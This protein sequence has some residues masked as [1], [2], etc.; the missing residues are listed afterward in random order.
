MT[1]VAFG[2]FDWID[3]STGASAPALQGPV[4]APRGGG[5]SRLL[6]LSPCGASRDPSRYGAIPSSSSSPPPLPLPLSARPPPPPL[7]SLPALSL[8]PSFSPSPPPSLPPPLLL[9]PSLLSLLFLLPSLPSPSSSP[10]H[11]LPSPLP[12]PPS[13]NDRASRSMRVTTRASPDRRK[14]SKTCSS[15][16]P[17]QRVPLAFS[18]RI[19]S[20]PAAFSAARW[21]PRQGTLHTR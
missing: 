7:L 1:Q 8:V 17:S 10:P 6:L 11:S 14:S 21:M 20:Q 16:R 9:S 19:T 15:V 3:R 5:C 2:L 12:P 4:A 13:R 18:A